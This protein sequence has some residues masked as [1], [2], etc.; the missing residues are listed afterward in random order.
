MKGCVYMS[1]NRI[2]MQFAQFLT[3]DGIKS[4]NPVTRGEENDTDTLGIGETN[5]SK[6]D[7]VLINPKLDKYIKGGMNETDLSKFFDLE[8]GEL[9]PEY[10]KVTDMGA[11]TIAGE[12]YTNRFVFTHA[13]DKNTFTEV[14]VMK[15]GEVRTDTMSKAVDN[16][17]DIKSTQESVF[18]RKKDTLLEQGFTEEMLEQYFDKTKWLNGDEAYKPKDGIKV[19]ITEGGKDP[20]T[21][22]ECSKI[23]SF[24]KVD[25]NGQEDKN[26]AVGYVYTD[27][28]S[29]TRPYT[30]QKNEMLAKGYSEEMLDQ[31]F[32]YSVDKNTGKGG[33]VLK[34]AYSNVEDMGAGTIAGKNY[35]HKFVFTSAENKNTLTEVTVMEDGTVK[36]K[37]TTNTLNDTTATSEDKNNGNAGRL[38]EKHNTLL[39]TFL[40]NLRKL[41]EKYNN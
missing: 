1:I 39:N 34:S 22:K 5:D 36:T 4:P 40:E 29:I 41:W 28:T 3:V 24:S 37:V 7:A 35:T 27:G 6:D 17:T 13:K 19:S 32:E 23:I 20:L 38:P 15:D 10:S 8:T 9:K 11:G 30:E 2:Q 33:Y 21:G 16:K 25:E 18:L 26:Y 14:M 12:N 31:Y